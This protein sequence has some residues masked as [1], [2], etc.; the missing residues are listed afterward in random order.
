MM[1]AVSAAG[2]LPNAADRPAGWLLAG[3]TGSGKTTFARRLE[4]EQILPQLSP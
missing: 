3:L 1:D 4:A 2:A